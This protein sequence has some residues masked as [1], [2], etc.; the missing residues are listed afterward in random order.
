[1]AL[2]RIKVQRSAFSVQGSELK[3]IGKK[4]GPRPI[5]VRGWRHAL[6][7][8]RLEVGGKKAKS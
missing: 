8:W 5:E 3:D 1:M 2:Y 6:R 7:G 4:G